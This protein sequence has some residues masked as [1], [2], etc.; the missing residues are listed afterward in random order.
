MKSPE[1]LCHRESLSSDK[2]L[3]R[4]KQWTGLCKEMWVKQ[5]WPWARQDEATA[6]SGHWGREMAIVREINFQLGFRRS[7]IQRVPQSTHS[8]SLMT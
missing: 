2:A 4:G 1:M 7:L 8:M 5:W 3:S 6:V